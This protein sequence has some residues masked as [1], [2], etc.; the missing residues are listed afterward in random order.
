MLMLLT[1]LVAALGL[2][3][4]VG[5]WYRERLGGYYASGTSLLGL[6]LVIFLVLVYVGAIHL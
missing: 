6:L 2:F 4:G 1:V 5:Y 3:G